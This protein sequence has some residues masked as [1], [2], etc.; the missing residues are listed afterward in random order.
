MCDTCIN[1]F[2]VYINFLK[3]VYTIDPKK[4]KAFL[5]M[6]LDENDKDDNPLRD[7]HL[8]EQVLTFLAAVSRTF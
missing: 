1:Y 3:L 7:V 6:L 2:L 8:R 4:K 5:D